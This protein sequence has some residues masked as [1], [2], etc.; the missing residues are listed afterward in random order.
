MRSTARALDHYRVL[1]LNYNATHE[2]IKHAFRRMAKAHH[3]DANPGSRTSIRQ[4]QLISEAHGVLSDAAQKSAYDISIGNRKKMQRA[5]F[6]PPKT[7]VPEQR[8]GKI[9]DY[10]EWTDMHFN[11]KRFQKTAAAEQAEINQHFQGQQRTFVIEPPK[12]SVSPLE[13]VDRLELVE[14]RQIKDTIVRRLKERRA[15]RTAAA[16]AAAASS[17]S[18]A[19][20]LTS[21]AASAASGAACVI[22]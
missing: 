19:G 14:K 1:G 7:P 17:S 22:S 4:F 5:P 10:Q 9:F 20:R 11:G 12:E 13:R 8:P 16:A 18:S 15:T 6:Q 21:A 3:P 2:E